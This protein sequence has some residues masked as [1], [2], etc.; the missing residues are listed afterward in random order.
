M[1]K[2]IHFFGQS[3]F[4]QLI[5]LI[6]R[7]KITESVSLHQSD[8]HCKG[9]YTWDHLVSMLFCTLGNCQSL[10]E[11]V[12]ACLGLKGKVE[13]LGLGRLPKR[14][15]LS[16]ANR[17]RNSAVF[18]SIYQELLK[19][20]RSDITDSRIRDQFGKEVFIIDSTTISLFQSILRCVGRKPKSGKQK[21]GIKVHTMIQADEKVPQVI[22]FSAATTHD[23]QFLKKVTF[24]KDALYLFDK[25]YVDYLRYEKFITEGISFVTRLKDNASYDSI[26]ELDIPEHIDPGVIKDEL[27]KLPIRKNGQTI[28]TIS[29]RRVAYWDDEQKRIIICLTNLIEV[30]ADVIPNLYKQRW[31]IETLFKQLKQNFPLKYFLGDNENAIK[32][33]VW[34]VLIANLLLTVIQEQIKSKKWAFSNIVSFVRLH[35]FNYIH[36]I[37]FLEN[38]EKDWEKEVINEPFDLFSG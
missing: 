9:F 14:S 28:R 38:P 5:S 32:I 35:L 33:Q 15:T 3:V 21:G 36:L 24:K 31:Q 8:K 30:E 25:G 23:S 12:G 6:D 4:G 20:Y 27:V 2:S 16:D 22:W 7:S 18:E 19:K 11:V 17:I 29:L 10:R 34:C 1:G 37:S 26:E 13:H